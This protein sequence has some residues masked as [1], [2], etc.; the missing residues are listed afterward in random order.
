MNIYEEVE[1]VGK[2]IEDTHADYATTR[3]WN[4]ILVFV[5]STLQEQKLQE[6]FGESQDVTT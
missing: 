4:K 1:A 5:I 6:K 2:Y 3:S